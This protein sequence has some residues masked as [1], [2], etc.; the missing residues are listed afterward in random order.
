MLRRRWR[1]HRV[2]PAR[3]A[4]AGRCNLLGIDGGRSSIGHPIE[5]MRGLT[6]R[7]DL[8]LASLDQTSRV[9]THRP[10]PHMEGDAGRQSPRRQKSGIQSTSGLRW[11]GPLASRP[12]SSRRYGVGAKSRRASSR[13]GI[14]ILIWFSSKGPVAAART[15]CCG[16]ELR[17][18]CLRPSTRRPLLHE[19]AFVTCF[20][21]QTSMRRSRSANGLKR[22]LTILIFYRVSDRDPVGRK[23][24]SDRSGR[25]DGG[26]GPTH[27]AVASGSGAVDDATYAV[28][29]TG[30]TRARRDRVGRV[31]LPRPTLTPLQP[32]SARPLRRGDGITQRSATSD[33]DLGLAILRLAADHHLYSRT[34]ENALVQQGGSRAK[35]K[36]VAE[37]VSKGEAA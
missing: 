37:C 9:A 5:E 4:Q 6:D 21:R 17:E 31:P 32:G 27:G 11:N 1:R 3:R 35:R 13:I 19:I 33:P 24:A 30:Y 15:R 25:G 18:P 29:R 8:A 26:A 14:G 22:G 28:K 36:P 34:V 7:V 12:A 20:I 10:L 16:A 23:N 2:I